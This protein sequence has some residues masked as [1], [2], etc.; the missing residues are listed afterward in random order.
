MVARLRAKSKSSTSPVIIN[1]VNPGLCKSALGRDNPNPATL[2]ARFYSLLQRTTEVGSRTYVLAACAGSSSH[3]Q[4]MS[5]GRNQ[6]VEAWIYTEV[7]KRAQEKVF[8]Q[9]MKVLEA[10][11][12]GIGAVAEV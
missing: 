3:G 7:G 1:L 11:K 4:F 10:R 8:D 12:P 6:D 2:K 9:T 5:D